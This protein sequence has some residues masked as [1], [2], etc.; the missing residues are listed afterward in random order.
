MPDI[1][2]LHNYEDSIV[3]F[4]LKFEVV[5][6]VQKIFIASK[7]NLFVTFIY[8]PY[9]YCN[10]QNPEMKIPLCYFPWIW[11]F[12]ACGLTQN[13]FHTNYSH[14]GPDSDFAS[15]RSQK[16]HLVFHFHF[17]YHLFVVFVHM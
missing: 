14:I 11:L 6:D 9:P 8:I 1:I 13:F 16:C 5:V 15:N 3:Y 17:N 4:L 12:K 2:I 7:E 10:Y